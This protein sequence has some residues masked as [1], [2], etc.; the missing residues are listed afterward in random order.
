MWLDIYVKI[1]AKYTH[2]PNEFASFSGGCKY[3]YNNN[4]FKPIFSRVFRNVNKV[5]IDIVRH[6]NR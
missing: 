1:V 4:I 2:K 3:S 5:I 6:W